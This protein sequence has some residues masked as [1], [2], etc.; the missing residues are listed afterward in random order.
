V[1]SSLASAAH[2]RRGFDVKCL[3]S[4]FENLNQAIIRHPSKEASIMCKRFLAFS[5]GLLVSLALV[6]LI[7]TLVLTSALQESLTDAA[8]ENATGVMRLY[9]MVGADPNG[10]IEEHGCDR[11]DVVYTLHG[12]AERGHNE[13]VKLLLDYGARVNLT[14]DYGHNALW[15]AV[16]GR[17]IETVRFLLS[18]GA[19]VNSP[20][21]T[22][23]ALEK[24]E[25]N[26]Y[27]EMVELLQ[28]AGAKE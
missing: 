12:A 9:L 25:G 16:N 1:G 15:H 22:Y 14:D 2:D 27:T 18:K 8:R 7:T 3:T 13:A 11:L 6:N 4:R 17:Q 26:G 20:G 21:E 19:A 24:A 10:S 28:Q 5:C 23:T